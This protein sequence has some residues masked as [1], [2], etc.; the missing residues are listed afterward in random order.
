MSRKWKPADGG[1]E[2]SRYTN[3]TSC[4]Y[5]PDF[6]RDVR[7]RHPEWFVDTAEEKKRELLA[8][9]VGC[10]RPSC[11]TFLGLALHYYIREMSS[12]Y[13]PVFDRAIKERQPGWFVDTVEENKKKLLA[14]SIGCKRPH[15]KTSIGVALC[16][17]I[18][19]GSDSYDPEF[20]EDIRKHQPGWWSADEKKKQLLALPIE[21]DRPIKGKH[22]LGVAIGTYTNKSSGSYDSSFDVA[23]KKRQP[24][25]FVSQTEKAEKKSLRHSIKR[26]HALRPCI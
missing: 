7:I 23:I 9:S 15:A 1:A 24:S 22:S 16:T 20:E 13:D 12:S 5:D 26:F 11:R 21:C 8:M 18:Y 10:V 4:S 3:K 19:K 14:M 17:Y 2:L 6:D 25:W